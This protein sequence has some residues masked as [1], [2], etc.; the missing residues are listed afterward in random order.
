M[1]PIKGASSHWYSLYY[2]VGY[3]GPRNHPHNNQ[4]NLQVYKMITRNTQGIIL[5]YDITSRK[6]FIDLNLV[7]LNEVKEYRFYK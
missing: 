5:V 7:W 1:F 6:S 3:Y 4:A 2:K